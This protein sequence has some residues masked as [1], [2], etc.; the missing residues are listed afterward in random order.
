MSESSLI[1]THPAEPYRIEVKV[2]PEYLSH[3]SEPENERF[4]FAYHVSIINCGSVGAQLL[5]RHWVITDGNGGVDEVLGEG[6]VGEQPYLEAGE[7]YMYNSFCVL[8]TPVG[9]MQG[10][11]G[12]I[13]D[14]GKLFEAEIPPFMLAVPGRLN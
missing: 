8:A 4:I 3:D 9:M 7:E 12:M 2:M 5:N 11:Y 1:D 14:D 6:V 13:S 10:S